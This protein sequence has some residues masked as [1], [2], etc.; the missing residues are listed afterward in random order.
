MKRLEELRDFL[1]ANKALRPEQ[2]RIVLENGEPAGA[3]STTGNGL[4]AFRHRYTGRVEIKNYSRPLTHLAAWVHVWLAEN[5]TRDE[6]LLGWSGEPTS[7]EESFLEFRFQIMEE[8]HYV[9]KPGNYTGDEAITYGGA[10]WI[11]GDEAA[12]SATALDGG[13]VEVD[14]A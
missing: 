13:D 12:N 5:G 2:L 7:D 9:T 3:F 4:L 6:E 8:I 1:V 10:N 14:L 11:P